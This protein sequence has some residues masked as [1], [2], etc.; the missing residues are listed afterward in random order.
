MASGG[1]RARRGAGEKLAYKQSILA[2]SREES[3]GASAA[4]QEDAEHSVQGTWSH[5]PTQRR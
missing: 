2:L 3:G 4:L 5:W 1:L